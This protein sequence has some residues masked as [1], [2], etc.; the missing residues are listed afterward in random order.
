MCVGS[1][2]P[3]LTKF[4][5]L[6]LEI[7]KN[8][9][10]KQETEARGS[11]L[12]SMAFRAKGIATNP[13]DPRLEALHVQGVDVDVVNAACDEA[14]RSKPNERIGLAYVL[15]IIER[16]S[17]EAS[18]LK[19]AG[20][21]VPAKAGGAWWASDATMLAKAQEVGVQSIPGESGDSFKARIS[22]AVENGGKPP[23]PKPRKENI[24]IREPEIK[25]TKPP[26]IDLRAAL[27]K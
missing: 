10:R 16:W 19:V 12:L 11:V 22:A 18:E 20:A 4:Q 7:Q 13:A 2:P 23:E 5:I 27:K 1:I 21:K 6:L 9:N 24:Q 15:S 8:G 17:R 14:K 26:H 25:R 3:N